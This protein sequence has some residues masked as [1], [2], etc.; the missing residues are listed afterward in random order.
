MV[1]GKLIVRDWGRG[2]SRGTGRVP[3]KRQVGFLTV[4]FLTISSLVN[5]SGCVLI[6]FSITRNKVVGF[7]MSQ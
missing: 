6:L 4:S 1:Q 2:L 3:H 5:A 7:V